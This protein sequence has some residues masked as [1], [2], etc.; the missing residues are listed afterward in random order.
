M[1]D[2]KLYVIGPFWLIAIACIL[3]WDCIWYIFMR[4]DYYEHIIVF[5]SY[6][7]AIC[8]TYSDEH[9]QESIP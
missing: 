1:P 2:V 5:V 7:V 4:I 3:H 8:I 9:S 6:F